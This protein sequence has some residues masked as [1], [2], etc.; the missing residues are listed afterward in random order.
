VFAIPL[1]ACFEGNLLLPKSFDNLISQKEGQW[2]GTGEEGN[3]RRWEGASL[4][5]LLVGLDRVHEKAD[6]TLRSAS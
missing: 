2:E 4:V 1:L 3:D 6:M 5:S